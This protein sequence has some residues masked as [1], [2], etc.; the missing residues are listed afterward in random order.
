VQYRV[1]SDPAGKVY[2]LPA[3][4]VARVEYADGRVVPGGALAATAAAPDASPTRPQGTPVVVNSGLSTGRSRPDYYRLHFTLGA[5]GAYF[6]DQLNAR[7]NDDSLGLGMNQTIGFNARL[8]YR[9]VRPL[10]VSITGGYWT[11]ELVRS[12]TLNGEEQY[13]ETRQMTRIPL[14]LGLKLYVF[15]GL[16]LMPEGGIVLTRTRVSTS[17][18]HPEPTSTSASLTPLTY[19]G[20]IGCE[21][22]AGPALIDISARYQ[23]LD[24]KDL[25]LSA[26]QGAFSERA[27]SVG[28]RIGIGFRALRKD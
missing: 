10:A 17:E 28:I 4:Q 6:P 22:G 16:Y 12:Y 24:V 8:D 5:E 11:W 20:S 21:I 25:S 19:G 3:D 15:R 1:S 14:Q 2:S 7:W 26:Q 13:Q 18:T 9:I 27:Q 23:I